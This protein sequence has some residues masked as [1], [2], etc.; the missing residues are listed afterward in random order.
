MRGV[1]L[2]GMHGER[3]HTLTQ[4]YRRARLHRVQPLPGS[5]PTTYSPCVAYPIPLAALRTLPA[6]YPSSF[7]SR[8]DTQRPEIP[9]CLQACLLLSVSRMAHFLHLG[10]TYAKWR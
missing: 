3:A 2:K 6:L 8:C 7:D 5:P 9:D 4:S 1:R 10:T